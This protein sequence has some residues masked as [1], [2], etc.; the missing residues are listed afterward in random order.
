MQ[1]YKNLCD[2]FDSKYLDVQTI[3]TGRNLFKEYQIGKE[4]RSRPF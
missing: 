3:Y 1:M 4:H 2:L